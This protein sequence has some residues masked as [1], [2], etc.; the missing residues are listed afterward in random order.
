M[1]VFPT[2]ILFPSLYLNQ[3]CLT[4]KVPATIFSGTLYFTGLLCRCIEGSHDQDESVVQT[5]Q[6]QSLLLIWEVNGMRSL[7]FVLLKLGRD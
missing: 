7:L 2:S 6:A 5:E 1:Y 3:G 4:Y